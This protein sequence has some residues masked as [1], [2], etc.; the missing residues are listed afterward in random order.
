MICDKYRGKNTGRQSV[1]LRSLKPGLPLIRTAGVLTQL[2]LVSARHNTISL[3]L[4]ILGM[5]AAA[6][7]VEKAKSVTV[8]GRDTVPFRAVLGEEIG[9]RLM[10]Q[11]KEKGVLFKMESGV[12]RFLADPS[13]DA[14]TQV[15]LTDGSTLPA[16]VCI[17]GTGA[18][19]ATKFLNGSGVSVDRRGAIIV[20][21]VMGI[22]FCCF[23]TVL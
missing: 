9:A 18:S 15:E 3:V 4:F 13:G 1:N 21:K 2:C 11:H 10:A 6:H 5:E 19:P 12:T 14:V 20:N 17:L 23:V 22:L 16:D 8:I 7:C